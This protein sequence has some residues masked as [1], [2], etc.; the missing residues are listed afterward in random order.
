MEQ[1][2]ASEMRK[3]IRRARLSSI[4]RQIAISRLV[5]EMDYVDI[6]AAVYMDR[7]SVSRR[8]RYKI[9]PRLEAMI[10]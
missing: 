8:M 4:D 7:T 5:W 10:Q 6:G 9:A 1:L 2:D 3:L